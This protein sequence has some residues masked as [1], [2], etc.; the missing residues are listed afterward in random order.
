MDFVGCGIWACL[1][2]LVPFA[3]LLFI[4]KEMNNSIFLGPPSSVA[5]LISKVAIYKDCEMSFGEKDVLQ[6]QHVRYPFKL[7]GLHRMWPNQ[8]EESNSLI[9]LSF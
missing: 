9:S 4:W 1:W 3:I 6:F 2:R 5:N 8:S 7:G